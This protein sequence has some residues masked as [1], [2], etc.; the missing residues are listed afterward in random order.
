M[1]MEESFSGENTQLVSPRLPASNR[2]VRLYGVWRG[3]LPKAREGA[4]NLK[5]RVARH[6]GPPNP[7]L[8]RRNNI[9]ALKWPGFS[10]SEREN[11]P[12]SPI[13]DLRGGGSSSAAASPSTYSSQTQPI[14]HIDSPPSSFKN[15]SLIS[16]TE[17]VETVE[18]SPDRNEV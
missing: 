14:T 12:N 2:H 5:A 11:T 9:M 4:S 18:A 6:P 15:F 1:S 3:V 7:D 16:R 13:C 10:T 17:N 8:G